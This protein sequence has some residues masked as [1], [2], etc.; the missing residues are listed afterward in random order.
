M[1][2]KDNLTDQAG[3]KFSQP[4]IPRLKKKIKQSNAIDIIVMSI[5]CVELEKVVTKICEVL[6]GA[7]VAFSGPIPLSVKRKRWTVRTSPHVYK[8]AVQVFESLLYRRLI[9]APRTREVIATLGGFEEI[10]PSVKIEIKGVEGG[11]K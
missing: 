4:V 10:A 1:L 9:R 7:L 5:D 11:I 6:N 2:L 3:S 8:D